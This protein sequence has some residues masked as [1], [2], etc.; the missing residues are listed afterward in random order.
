[1]KNLIK[2]DFFVQSLLLAGALG[3]LFIVPFNRNIIL[4]LLP[5]QALLG[6]WQFLGSVGA[7]VFKGLSWKIKRLYLLTCCLYLFVLLVFAR[8][9]TPDTIL[10]MSSLILGLFV[11]P[12]TLA[13]LYYA[14]TLKIYKSTRESGHGFLPHTSS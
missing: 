12:W 10:G 14:I 6:T 8:F 9:H 7:V 3:S 2:I 4:F 13:V 1:M 11:I 5:L